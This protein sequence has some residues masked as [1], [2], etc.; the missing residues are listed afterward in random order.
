MNFIDRLFD[1]YRKRLIMVFLFIALM[2]IIASVN[3]YLLGDFLTH[4][5]KVSDIFTLIDYKVVYQTFIGQFLIAYLDTNNILVSFINSLGMYRI[6]S[7]IFIIFFIGSKHDDKI[8]KQLRLI[9]LFIVVLILM[10]Y[11][12]IGFEGLGALNAKDSIIGIKALVTVGYI[13]KYTSLVLIISNILA[14]VYLITKLI[15]RKELS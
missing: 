11:L 4:M 14:M 8:L 7:V 2:L 6:A 10:E 15:G 3:D 13:L 12:M 9:T 1:T 5:S